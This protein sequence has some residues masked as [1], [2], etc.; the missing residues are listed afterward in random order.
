META[1]YA[2]S[3][4]NPVKSQETEVHLSE[5]KHEDAVTPLSNVT[6]RNRRVFGL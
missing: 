2:R 4:K 1:V 5:L 6:T 3:M